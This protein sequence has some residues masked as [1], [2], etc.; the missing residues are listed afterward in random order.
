MIVASDDVLGGSDP[1]EGGEPLGDLE[2][3]GVSRPVTGLRYRPAS[4]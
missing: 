4:T 3:K 1:P 2:L